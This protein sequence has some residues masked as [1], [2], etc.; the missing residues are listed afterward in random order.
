VPPLL[1]IAE[2]G[3]NAVLSWSTNEI[4]FSLVAATNLAPNTVWSTVTNSIVVVGDQNTVTVAA[5]SSR[6]FF[7]LKR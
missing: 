1:Q 6:Q 7:R 3:T 2:M 5:N 4:D